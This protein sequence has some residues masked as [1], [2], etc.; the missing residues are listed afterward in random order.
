VTPLATTTPSAGATATLVPTPTPTSTSDAGEINGLADA[1]AAKTAAKCQQAIGKAGVSFLATRLKQLDGCAAGIL[2]CVQTKPD[3][4][5]CVPKAKAKCVAAAAARAKLLAAVQSKCGTTLATMADLGVRGLGYEDLDTDCTSELGH[6]PANVAEVAECVARRYSCRANQLYAMQ[7][8]RAGELLRVA[9]VEADD[10]LPDHGGDGDGVDDVV[11]GKVIPQCAAAITKSASG[12]IV[13]KLSSLATC[14]D[15]VFACIQTKPGDKACLAKADAA[16]GKEGAKIAAEGA[17]VGPA[18]DKKCGG[19]DFNADLLPP[20]AVNLAALVTIL[21][22]ADTL[23]TLTHYEQALRLQHDCAA[24]E[25][26]RA[27]APRA[28]V[29]LRA[30]APLAPSLSIPSAGCAAP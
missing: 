21:P 26:L 1:V 22:G 27:I 23:D 16:C 19:I 9:G 28:E 12:F 4:K 14:V 18:I 11:Q 5:G 10:C 15:K 8:P 7:A 2:K 6:A 25:L 24:K 30:L 29:L 20:R 3:D 13:K 17:K